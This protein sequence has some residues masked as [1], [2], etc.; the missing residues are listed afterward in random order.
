MT[1]LW[2][3]MLGP[4]LGGVVLAAGWWSIRG[5]RAGLHGRAPRAAAILVGT[6]L[7]VATAAQRVG[8]TGGILL[9]VL[10]TEAW[11][12][13]S[14]VRFTAPLVLGIGALLALAFPIEPR[15]RGRTADLAPRTPMSFARGSWLVVPTLVLAVIA[16]LTVVAGRASRPD[17]Q[18]GRHTFY[19]V[20]PGGENL[21]GTT[22]YGWYHSL[23]SLVLIAVMI[24]VVALDL[25]LIARPALDADREQDARQRRIRTRN[26]V[27]VATGALLVHLGSVLSSLGDTASLRGSFATSE[28]GVSVWTPFAALEHV[29]R[30]GAI[31]AVALGIA[32]WASVALSALPARRRTRT[33]AVS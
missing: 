1:I 10:S 17:P 5:S 7:I 13:V 11:E 19:F 9:P 22:I 30:W 14:D 15:R 6:L 23:P 20:E 3:M 21:L 18:T 12:F 26:V 32:F 24:V 16:S 25:V 8:E 29:L 28:G 27:S 4:I 31:A 33:R 2:A